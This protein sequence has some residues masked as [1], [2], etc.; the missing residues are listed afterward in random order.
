MNIQIS[1]KHIDISDAYHAHVLQGFQQ[2]S[3]KYAVNPIEIHVTIT[4]HDHQ[5]ACQVNA[6]IGRGLHMRC[7]E[8]GTD[9]YTAFDNSI[10]KLGKILSKHKERLKKHHHDSA[11]VRAEAAAHY[12]WSEDHDDEG[13]PAVVAEMHTHIPLLT[14]GEA[15]MRFELQ[16]EPYLLFYN[17]AHGRLNLVHYRADGNIGWIDPTPKAQ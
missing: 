11:E 13:H 14:V 6:H 10:V 16:N 15:V 4:K 1:G 12:V 8:N 2:L 7:H 3:D 17:K 9:A 5:F